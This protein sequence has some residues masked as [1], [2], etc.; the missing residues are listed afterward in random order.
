MQGVSNKHCLLTFFIEVVYVW[1]MYFF[2]C[3]DSG[4]LFSKVKTKD[5]KIVS[6]QVIFFSFTLN[7]FAVFE[8]LKVFT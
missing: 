3:M 8:F 6:I 7:S 5:I 2:H 1:L 4:Q